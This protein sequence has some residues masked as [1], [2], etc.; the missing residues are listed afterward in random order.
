[1]PASFMECRSVCVLQCYPLLYVQQVL[2]YRDDWVQ[3]KFL[4]TILLITEIYKNP[5]IQGHWG[6]ESFFNPL[7]CEDRDNWGP[8]NWGLAVQCT[9]EEIGNPQIVLILIYCCCCSLA[10]VIF[11]AKFYFK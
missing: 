6:L 10:D 7:Y 2:D 3:K 8:N 4:D 1:M 5:G 9:L 11:P